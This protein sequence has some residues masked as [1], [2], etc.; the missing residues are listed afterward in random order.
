MRRM[1]LAVSMVVSLWPVAWIASGVIAAVSK[2]PSSSS[3]SASSTHQSDAAQTTSST[4]QGGSPT[5]AATVDVVGFRRLHTRE[6]QLLQQLRTSQSTKGSPDV[7]LSEGASALVADLG[8]WESRNTGAPA[9]A[10][11]EARLEA[12]LA[13]RIAEF[14]RGPS[15]RRLGAINEAISTFN[16]VVPSGSP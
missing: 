6:V 15:Q 7:R 10:E 13:E 2:S 14:A 3:D 8:T 11:K 9:L 1:L 5:T 16:A 12:A 4:E